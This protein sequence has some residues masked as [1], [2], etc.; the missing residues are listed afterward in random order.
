MSL[1]LRGGL[2]QGLRV[3]R[4]RNHHFGFSEGRT[5]PAFAGMGLAVAGFGGGVE[6]DPDFNSAG[7]TG[8]S[9]RR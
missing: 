8:F 7:Q 6:R 5:K 9:A 1:Q 2:R 4:Y 3:G